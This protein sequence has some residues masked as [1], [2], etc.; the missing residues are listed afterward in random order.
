MPSYRHF[1]ERWRQWGDESKFRFY[2]HGAFGLFFAA[3]PAIAGEKPSRPSTVSF[4]SR[5]TFVLSR[6]SF[7]R[8][9]R[10]DVLCFANRTPTEAIRPASRTSAGSYSN[11]PKVLH[12]SGVRIHTNTHTFFS[13]LGRHKC[14]PVYSLTFS[15]SFVQNFT[16]YQNNQTGK[17]IAPLFAFGYANVYHTFNFF[18]QT[19]ITNSRY[20][21]IFT[22]LGT[23]DARDVSYLFLHCRPF[24]VWQ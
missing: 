6:Q 14:K 11:Y 17:W 5:K 12:R 10:T 19:E 22:L 8:Y 3:L 24:T 16:R 21:F 2:L 1:V 9:R 13:L 23:T 15:C 18:H 4:D 20:Y 7:Y